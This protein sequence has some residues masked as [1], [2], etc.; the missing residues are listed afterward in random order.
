M[1]LLKLQNKID[2]NIALYNKNKKEVVYLS[3]AITNNPNRV[4]DFSKAQNFLEKAGYSVF[5]PIMMPPGMGYISYI[6][7][8]KTILQEVD[9]ICMLDGW[10]KSAGA[11]IELRYAKELKKEVIHIKKFKVGGGYSYAIV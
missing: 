1:E 4:E 5:N 10:E 9:Y 7:I 8:A 2:E 3:G 11:N 6:N